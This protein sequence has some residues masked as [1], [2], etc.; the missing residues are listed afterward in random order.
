MFAT[1]DNTVVL[2]GYARV[3]AAGFLTLSPKFRLQVNVETLLDT[4]YLDLTLRPFLLI[5]SFGIRDG[6]RHSPGRDF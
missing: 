1:I 2:P 6:S 5:R 3:D 4:K